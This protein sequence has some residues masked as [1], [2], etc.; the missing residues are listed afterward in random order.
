MEMDLRGI[1]IYPG[2]VYSMVELLLGF[3]SI[4]SVVIILER[5]WVHWRTR[6]RERGFTARL[7]PLLDT[8]PWADIVRVAQDREVSRV[9]AARALRAGLET[10]LAPAS[11]GTDPVIAW[12]VTRDAMLRSAALGLAELKRGLRALMITAIT[13]FLTG[14]LGCVYELHNAFEGVS[15]TG[16]GGLAA[17]SLGVAHALTA[18]AW[19]LLIALVAI[20]GYAWLSTSSERMRLETRGVIDDV[21]GRLARSRPTREP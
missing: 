9:P 7:Q 17:V 12:F 5:I 11:L 18:P 15:L 8:A 3:L 6:R 20:L 13:A 4:Y 14:L 19:G 16:A 2:P 21:L 1:D 10:R